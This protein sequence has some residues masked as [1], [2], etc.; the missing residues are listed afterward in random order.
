MDF[1]SGRRAG[2]HYANADS[3]ASHSLRRRFVSDDIGMPSS[4]SAPHQ[5]KLFCHFSRSNGLVAIK[6]AWIFQ[7]SI[8]WRGSLLRIFSALAAIESIIIHQWIYGRMSRRSDR[9]RMPPLRSLFI[10]LA[11]KRSVWS[12]KYIWLS[13][14]SFGFGPLLTCAHCRGIECA[15]TVASDGFEAKIERNRTNES[16][17][18]STKMANELMKSFIV[19]KWNKL[20]NCN[21]EQRA[22]EVFLFASVTN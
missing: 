12:K 7:T 9:W 17:R 4:P 21:G 15:A 1:S 11:P 5:N 3:N 16:G 22:A 19:M 20:T 13:F 10:R 8:D 2:A 14:D 6:C 18:R